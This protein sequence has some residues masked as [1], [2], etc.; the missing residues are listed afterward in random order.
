MASNDIT[1]EIARTLIHRLTASVDDVAPII[2]FVATNESGKSS[3]CE[4]KEAPAD[5][6]LCLE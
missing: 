3:D 5:R 6:F 1:T 4:L 2:Y